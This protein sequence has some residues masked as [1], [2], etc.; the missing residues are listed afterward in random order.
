MYS[1]FSAR[2]CL[3]WLARR[4]T[5]VESPFPH[6]PRR[7]AHGDE[8][9]QRRKEE[10]DLRRLLPFVQKGPEPDDHHSDARP[11]DQREDR[12]EPTPLGKHHP[13][14]P[15]DEPAEPHTHN[16]ES[17]PRLFHPAMMNCSVA[18]RQRRHGVATGTPSPRA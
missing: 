15:R 6:G 5:L 17:H 2:L 14:D 8:A 11:R 16:P 9:E 12:A 10:R 4:K 3:G 18:L 13:D 7:S 1:V